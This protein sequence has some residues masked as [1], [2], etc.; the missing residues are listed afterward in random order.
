[1]AKVENDIKRKQLRKLEAYHRAFTG[2]EGKIVLHDLIKT[3]YILQTTHVPM[4]P[5]ATAHNEGE[6]NAVIRILSILKT[7]PA[8]MQKMMEEASDENL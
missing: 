2:P 8:K 5:V 3:H 6:R 7:T 1:M 4:D